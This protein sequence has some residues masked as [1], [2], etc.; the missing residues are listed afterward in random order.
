MVPRR[1]GGGAKRAGSIGLRQVS[2]PHPSPRT[3]VVVGGTKRN[4]DA[5]ILL[6]S[7]SS[8][9]PGKV[10]TR[11]SGMH[12]PH[13]PITPRA[14]ADAPEQGQVV[15]TLVDLLTEVTKTRQRGP[16][17]LPRPTHTRSQAPE[18]STPHWRVAQP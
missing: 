4:T 8:V 7:T 9:H 5:L 16:L 6:V 12:R 10:S 11:T 14:L 17:R 3:G 15:G 13:H 2:T 18:K 1:A